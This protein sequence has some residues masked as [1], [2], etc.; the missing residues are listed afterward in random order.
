[1]TVVIAIIAILAECL[2]SLS[3][4]AQPTITRQP[5]DKFLD[6]G[7]SATFPGPGVKGT[8]PF[9]FQWLFDGRAIARATNYTLQVTNAQPAQSDGYYSVIV[10]NASGSVTSQVARLKVFVP[11]PHDFSSI[12]VMS[13][14]SA[15][16]AFTG[17]TTA[18]FGPYYDLYPLD[19]SSNLV[20]WT[21]LALLQRTNAA[22]DRMA[23]S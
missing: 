20:D 12:G 21:P 4:L 14:R 15:S 2:A 16:L 3:A 1:M 5:G 23:R 19:V 7:K 13:G 11:A 17:E 6:Q 10:A 8:P 18:L 9:S 22:L